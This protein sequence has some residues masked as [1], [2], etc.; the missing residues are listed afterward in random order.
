MTGHTFTKSEIRLAVHLLEEAIK[1]YFGE[2]W[3][4]KS[5]GEYKGVTW[6]CRSPIAFDAG[7]WRLC[8][9]ARHR[10]AT[11]AAGRID[12]KDGGDMLLFTILYNP[13]KEKQELIV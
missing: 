13:L 11:R 3:S 5:D 10:D 8:Q 6:E 9:A 1:K 4:I 2:V 7:I 12:V